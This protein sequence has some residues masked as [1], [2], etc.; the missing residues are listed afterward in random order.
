MIWILFINGYN[1]MIPVAAYSDKETA[2]IAR[3]I[4]AGFNS[5][6]EE[7]GL[8]IQAYH[9]AQGCAC[10]RVTCTPASKEAN[11]VW[12]CEPFIEE[13]EARKSMNIIVYAYNEYLAVKQAEN[14]LA[15]RKARGEWV[16]E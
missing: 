2:N 13:D 6:I 4:Y 10:Y 7:V 9:I 3:Q 16:P 8:D 1:G 15:D 5:Y 12:P 14:V 11:K